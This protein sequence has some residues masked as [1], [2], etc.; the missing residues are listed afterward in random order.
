MAVMI[1]LFGTLNLQLHTAIMMQQNSVLHMLKN[2]NYW[3][4]FAKN[5]IQNRFRRSVLGPFW[6][7][8]TSLVMISALGYIFVNFFGLDTQSYLPYL[9]VGVIMWGFISTTISESSLIF[10]SHG[11][12]IQNVPFPLLS[13]YY[14]VIAVN[15]IILSINMCII[16]VV[17][18]AVNAT[19]TYDIFYVILTLPIFLLNIYWIGLLVAIMCARFRDVPHM[20]TN[21][22]QVMFFIT[23]VFW[24]PEN[25]ANRPA[26]LALNPFYHL[27]EIIRAPLTGQEPWITSIVLLGLSGVIGC[28][29]IN[30]LFKRVAH[31]L[32]YWV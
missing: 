14:R 3:M 21:I 5:D 4:P 27:L 8:I 13:L 20:V 19:V 9:S 16:A 11:R 31:K 17:F 30:I 23:P 28:V 7:A 32:P 29:I 18:F 2:S 12:A 24:R 1:N 26:F 15:L 10:I 22:L 25:L 6:V